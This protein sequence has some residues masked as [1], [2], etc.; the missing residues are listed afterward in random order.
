[1]VEKSMSVEIVELLLAIL[2]VFAL[3]SLINF[4]GNISRGNSL[5]YSLNESYLTFTG[6]FKTRNMSL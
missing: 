4:L 6:F 1:M 3:F 5:K 2:L